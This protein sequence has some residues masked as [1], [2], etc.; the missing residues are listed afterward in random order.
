V[1]RLGLGLLL[2]GLSSSVLLISDW[3]QRRTSGGRVKRVALVQHA[4]QPLLDEGAA[5][6][7]DAL[8]EAGFVE[9]QILAVQRFNAENDLPTANAIARQVAA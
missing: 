6:M 9:G 1:R 7:L 3:R 4:S 2:I 8:A 5:G